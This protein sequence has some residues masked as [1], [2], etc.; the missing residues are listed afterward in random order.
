MATDIRQ[1]RVHPL[2]EPLLAGITEAPAGLS[3]AD[4]RDFAARRAADLTKRYVRPGPEPAVIA[5]LTI[6]V[7]GGEIPLRIYR[8]ADDGPLPAHVFLH[9]GGFWL[10]SLD[11]ADVACREF[12]AAAG[13]VVVSVGYRLA[14]EHRFPVPP[15]DSYAA[16]RHVVEHAEELGVERRQI[17]VG[18]ESAGATL[19]TVVCLMARDRGDPPPVLQVLAMPVTDL[20]MGH[21][22][23]ETF[24][25]GHLFTKAAMTTL[26][27]HY[28]GETGDARDP[29][30]SPL[31]APDLA[32]LP[33]ALVATMECDPLRDEGEAYARRLVE[34]GVSVLS[35]RF[36]GHVHGSTRFTALFPDAAGY[37]ALGA[38]AMRAAYAR[39]RQ[40]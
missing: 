5:D 17:S 34:A 31:H 14:P 11:G 1:P 18:G 26:V 7:P 24:A 25:E 19:A 40:Q 9:G 23:L 20:T 12:A 35:R 16:Y 22:S 4:A 10:G 38:L 37:Y 33:P 15:E 2:L 32:G 36:L 8:P 29:Y 3:V 21:Q 27:G 39:A 30:A 6:A 13:A 28:L